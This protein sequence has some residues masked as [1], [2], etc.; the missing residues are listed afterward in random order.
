ML[1]HEKCTFRW[2]SLGG[3]SASSVVRRGTGCWTGEGGCDSSSLKD[4]STLRFTED[5]VFGGG[6]P[7]L[8]NSVGSV[9]PIYYGYQ[10]W[11]ETHGFQ[12]L[13]CKLEHDRPSFGSF[14]LFLACF[15]SLLE[16]ET[17]TD[18]RNKQQKRKY[19]DRYSWWS[20]WH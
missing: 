20:W 14:L 15:C 9:S 8:E 12:V 10:D 16:A 13:S 2:S 11:T 6:G 5:E 7:Q 1:N 17:P 19:G 18:H 3:G 4:F